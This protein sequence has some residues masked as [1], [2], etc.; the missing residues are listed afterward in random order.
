MDNS[1]RII[2]LGVQLIT[3]IVSIAGFVMVKF[4]DLKHLE[5]KIQEIDA[6]MERFNTDTK[7]QSSETGADYKQ[8]HRDNKRE[9]KELTKI[10]TEIATV[11]ANRMGICETRH[12]K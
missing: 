6:K 7:A 3:I 5:N 2:S 12:S 9:I 11:Q 10:M 8:M 1:Y 4:N